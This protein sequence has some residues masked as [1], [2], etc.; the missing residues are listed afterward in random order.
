MSSRRILLGS[1]LFCVAGVAVA[2]FLGESI[3]FSLEEHRM[4]FFEL[5]LPRALLGMACGAGLAAAGVV[6]QAIL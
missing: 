6:L 5:R 2:P 4:I 1:L 3:D